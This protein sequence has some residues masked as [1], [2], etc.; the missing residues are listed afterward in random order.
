MRSTLLTL[1]FSALILVSCDKDEEVITSNGGQNNTQST[2]SNK[3]MP[4]GASRVEGARPDY[5]SYR[6]ELWKQLIDGGWEFDFIGNELDD[7]SYPNY[8]NL[9][10]DGDHQGIG[11]WTSGQLLD[12]VST[13]ITNTG[14]PDIVLL[15]P[16]EGMTLF[17]DSH[18]MMLLA[19]SMRSSTSFR[20][21]IRMSPSLLSKWPLETLKL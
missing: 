17:K 16:L 10:F 5:E 21:T 13:W 18:M 11:G 20:P 6:Y 14:S 3:I 1:L 7:A 9:S 19:T 12:A 2:S 15:A 8:N 4:F